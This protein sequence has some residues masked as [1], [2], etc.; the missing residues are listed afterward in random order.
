MPAQLT[1]LGRLIRVF[2]GIKE[3]TTDILA[4]NTGVSQAELIELEFG[5]R[6]PTTKYVEKIIAGFAFED[7]PRS[8]LSALQKR[9]LRIAAVQTGELPGLDMLIRHLHH[10]GEETESFIKQLE[11]ETG[12][13]IDEL[14]AQAITISDE[15]NNLTVEIM[16][17]ARNTYGLAIE[18]LLEPGPIL[19]F[20]LVS[21]RIYWHLG[22]PSRS[23][24]G[25]ALKLVLKEKD[26][27]SFISPK[28]IL[29]REEVISLMS[30]R[31]KVTPEYVMKLSQSF[32]HIGNPLTEAERDMLK[33]YAGF[34]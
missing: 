26:L 2:R 11:R 9:E 24:F 20:A 6:N 1:E 7:E 34:A 19:G 16:T 15:G 13:S 17:V 23:F 18:H 14:Q 4:E 3:I 33:D 30:G 5:L 25:D 8:G 12:L 10:T 32:A 21:G 31:V 28:N 29:S 22:G 27:I